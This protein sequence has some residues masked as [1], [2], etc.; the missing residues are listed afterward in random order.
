MA[1]QI[2]KIFETWQK[3]KLEEEPTTTAEN[4]SSAVI[5]LK[6]SSSK[7]ILL[8]SDAGVPPLSS[9]A[10]KLS[11][12]GIKDQIVYYQIPHHGS[13]HNVNTQLLNNLIGNILDENSTISKGA[14][15][16][17]AKNSDYKHPSQ[18]VINAFVRRGIRPVMTKGCN[19]CKHSDD[20]P[21]REGYSP[22]KQLEFCSDYEVE[23]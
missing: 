6:I 20:I 23:G 16:S 10:E 7:Y 15:V 2:K 3:D 1:K 14:C 21:T 11:E 5:L 17:V 18:A 4:N 22:A 8:T 12:M 19:L 9:V 13:R